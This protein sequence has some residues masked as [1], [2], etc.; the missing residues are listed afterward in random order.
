MATDL[1]TSLSPAGGSKQGF[2][3]AEARIPSHPAVS[4]GPLGLA[5]FLRPPCLTL[6][7]GR[8]VLQVKKD[9]AVLSNSDPS[10]VLAF[11]LC[12]AISSIS[13]SFMVS[14][15][16]SKGESCCSPQAR[17]LG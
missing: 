5:L 2:P 7:L 8:P 15:F 12:F 3:L 14:T 6:P 10:L 13:F 4:L 11:L 1:R 9:V 17:G 16:F